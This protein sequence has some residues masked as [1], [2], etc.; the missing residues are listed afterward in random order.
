MK[1]FLEGLFMA[2]EMF[3]AIV[4][5]LSELIGE[6]LSV[7]FPFVLLA[8]LLFIIASIMF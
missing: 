1:L 4:Q 6:F 2:F 7:L 5:D 8:W 3:W